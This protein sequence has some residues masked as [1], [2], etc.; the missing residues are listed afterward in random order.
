MTAIRSF[1]VIIL[2]FCCRYGH[3]RKSSINYD[4]LVQLSNKVILLDDKF[5]ENRLAKRPDV[6]AMVSSEID[7]VL[8]KD[9]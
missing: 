6:L 7:K 4:L 3:N 1:S 2:L 8:G 9:E 5:F